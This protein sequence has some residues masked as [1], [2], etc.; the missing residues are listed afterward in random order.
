V[1]T[2]P[3]NDPYGQ[4]QP[5]SG[6]PYGQQPPPPNPYGAPSYPGGPGYGA[7]GGQ[8]PK[9][10]GM[11]VA[12]LVSGLLCCA[13]VSLVLGFIGLGRTKGGQRKGR[14]MAIA[15]IVLGLLGLVAWVGIAIAGVA[16]VSF[17]DS[18]VTPG[19]A[20]VGQCVNI[21]EDD[22]EVFLREK[23]CNE[24][25]D[26]EI[27]GVKEITE[28]NLDEAEG[29][30]VSYC[31]EVIADDDLAKLAEHL[32]DIEAVT[33]DPTNVEVGD[34]IVC[35]VHSDEKLTEPIL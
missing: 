35:Y 19:N 10:D 32:D 24:E 16:G 2:P 9:T 34:H 12:A 33:E 17:L 23:D 18:I 27:V 6:D 30:M 4:Y 22:D 3:G 31:Q 26:G 11:S 1:T 15:G 14:G 21:D 5:P 28:D 25:H 13:P 29:A 8:P 7:P 20:E